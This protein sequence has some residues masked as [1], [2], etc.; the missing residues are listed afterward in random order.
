MVALCEAVVI[1][2]TDPLYLLLLAPV[3]FGLWWSYRHVHGMARGRKRFAFFVRGVLAV[4]LIGALAGP[5][6]LRPNVGVCTIFLVDRSDSVGDEDRQRANEFVDQALRQIAP[7][8]RGG[9]VVFGKDAA[10]DAAPGGRRELGPLLS[11]IDPSAS[12]LAGA[13]RLASAAFPEGKA[14]RIVVLS[15]GNETAGDA[16]EAAEVARVDRVPIDVVPL[17]VQEATLEVAVLDL[18][19][20]TEIRAGEPFDIRVIV[21]ASRPATGVLSLDRNGRVTQ[22][23]RVR[24]DA[25]KNALVV[26][27]KLEDAGFHRFRAT[28]KVDGDRD[29]RNNVGM[30]FIAV[31]GKPRVLLAQGKL[32]D[33]VLADAIAEKGIDVELVGPGGLPARPEDF[34][35]FDA[36]IFNDLNASTIT[37]SQMRRVQVA[38]RESGIGFAM[39]G[40]EDS[41]LP[42]G[43]YGTPIAEALPVDLN[44]RQR[45][46]FPST[47]IL[48]MVDASGSMA[49]EE[50][51]MTKIRLAAKAAEE[52]VKLMSPL[53]RVGVGGSTDGIEMVAPMQRLTDKASVI[54]QIRRLSTGG[55]GIYCRPTVQRAEAILNA[56][57]SK[58]RHFILLADGADCDQQD[59][60]NPVIA[61]MRLSKITTSVVAIG[62]GPDVPFLKQ[63]ARIGGGRF[64]L[65]KRAGQLP[66]IFTQDA[67]VMSRSAIEEGAF[68]PK[69]QAGEEILRGIDLGSIPA[70][71]AYCLTDHRPLA[72][73]GMRTAKD[74]PL[75]ATWQ[76]G[77]GTTLAFTSDA[78]PRWAA[79]WVGWEG[80]S[81][82]WAQATRAISRRA[83]KNDYQTSVRYVGGKGRVE[84]KA[85]D[86]FGNALPT[87]DAEVRVATPSGSA[88][89]I[90][91]TQQAPG[92]FSGEF[93]AGEL[94][95]YIVT[96]AE[97]D[98]GGGKRVDA[99]G[100][101]IPYPAEYRTYR[102]NTAL[103]ERLAEVTEG[104][105]LERPEDSF[106]PVP[107]AGQS[108]SELWPL[109]V[110]LA[111][112][113]LPFDVGVRRIALPI[114]EMLAR[115]WGWLRSRRTR[116][117]Q[118]TTGT[119][120]ERLQRAKERVTRRPGAAP[121]PIAIDRAAEQPAPRREP[122]A[123]SGDSAAKR[124]LE[125]KRKREQ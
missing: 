40:G 119:T 37:E 86:K 69:V 2:F 22:E 63:L 74:D 70:L 100:F 108:I 5:E 96:V 61:R 101:S 10:I 32:D 17:G 42:G 125:A 57:P 89:E 45:K 38:I 41:F 26:P 3:L 97:N 20:P 84:V 11:K 18:E 23:I 65:A 28:L 21:D 44:I 33:R 115:A 15:D 122:V 67:A 14:R 75:L 124:L 43:W 78:Q 113:L 80:F 121:D 77:L 92:V 64:Y 46:S 31:H 54:S 47:S 58:V 59:G 53:D 62:D 36:V 12:D 56:E 24:L 120:V 110:F 116:P 52:T 95:S 88:K 85:F 118:H 49:M 1:R 93:E 123:P 51:G 35:N 109:F 107:D 6:A 25:G 103:L 16:E 104:R 102:T 106:R 71:Y 30:G 82:F 27:Q 112:L 111:A 19:A 94:G 68:L 50:D 8:D 55:G 90:A 98:A 4:L 13:I 76:Y 9:V 81:Q 114:G 79:Q 72:R 66:A 7:E 99:T 60:C 34:Q 87:I 29:I 48:I 117:L 83:T 91:L 39:V 73:T 105:T